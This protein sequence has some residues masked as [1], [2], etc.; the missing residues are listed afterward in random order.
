[1]PTA[2]RKIYTNDQNSFLG[3]ILPGLI[4]IAS[5]A[6]DL[7]IVLICA[8]NLKLSVA[9]IFHKLGKKAYLV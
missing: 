1:M 4:L 2:A 3:G 9:D 7:S 6:V 8:Y 5:E